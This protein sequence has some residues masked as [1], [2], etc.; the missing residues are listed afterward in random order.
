MLDEQEKQCLNE[1]ASGHEPALR[2]LFDAHYR[3]ACQVA[4]RL[5]PDSEACKDIAQE[6]FVEIWRKRAELD[7]RGPFRA[8]LRRAVLNR[9]LNHL[10]SQR[11]YQFSANDEE[12]LAHAPPESEAPDPGHAASLDAALH[13]AIQNLPEKC[14][15]VFSL[16][17]FEELSHKEIAERLD[18]ST[19][20]IENQITKALRTL[21]EVLARHPIL[22]AIGIW[23]ANAWLTNRG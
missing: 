18:I 5:L 3:Y 15:L 8:Y 13:A 12:I 6:T 19:K 20:T 17:R 10:K 22:S 1:L 2:Q 4:H 16:S 23:L 21:R 7:I 9:T 14:R 11:R